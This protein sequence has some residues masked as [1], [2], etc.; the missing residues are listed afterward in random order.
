MCSQKFNDRLQGNMSI[1]IKCK[2][3][4]CS[5]YFYIF[6]IYVFNSKFYYTQLC[7]HVFLQTKGMYELYCESNKKQ[8]DCI[9]DE[10]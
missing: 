9:L 5:I 4:L 6:Y 10:S 3:H 8:G 1:N 2:T 7:V